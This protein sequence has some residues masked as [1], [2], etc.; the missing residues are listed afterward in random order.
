MESWLG[1]QWLQDIAEVLSEGGGGLGFGEKDW[2]LMCLQFLMGDAGE[3]A[4]QPASARAHR[5]L[6]SEALHRKEADRE[7]LVLPQ[8]HSNPA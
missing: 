1:A 4:E 2:G 6:T 8:T 3:G 7:T 5:A